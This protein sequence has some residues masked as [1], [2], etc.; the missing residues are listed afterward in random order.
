MKKIP[1]AP[2]KTGK[3]YE[4]R[5]VWGQKLG[6]AFEFRT[7]QNAPAILVQN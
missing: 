7:G 2:G 3:I 4:A 6:P 1:M 5:T